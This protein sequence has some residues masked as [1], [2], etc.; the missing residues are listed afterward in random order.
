MQNV[1]LKI[2]NAD[3]IITVL[4]DLFIF[5]II[6]PYLYFIKISCFKILHF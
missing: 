6:L 1:K 4:M 3:V 5:L 2:K